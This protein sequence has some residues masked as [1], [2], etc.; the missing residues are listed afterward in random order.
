MS[1]SNQQAS[2]DNPIK[3][4]AEWKGGNGE[5]RLY[6]FQTEEVSFTKK[7]FS[8]LILDEYIG[9]RGYDSTAES[10]IISNNIK[11]SAGVVTV[12]NKKNMQLD[13]GPYS[14]V[15]LRMKSYGGKYAKVLYGVLLVKGKPTDLIVIDVVGS[16]SQEYMDKFK[17]MKSYN[18]VGMVIT[19]GA[20][21]EQQKKGATKY[22]IPT[23]EFERSV[24]DAVKAECV[25]I[26]SDTLQ[27]YLAQFSTDSP[28]KDTQ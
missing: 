23:M 4:H 26:D 13:E 16:A 8:V 25:T 12:R 19:F 14:E 1:L 6:N 10:G 2:L 3:F 24:D 7:N 15:K 21:P 9:V 11:N 5:W 22:Y 28:K 17:P 20:N 18:S 27:P